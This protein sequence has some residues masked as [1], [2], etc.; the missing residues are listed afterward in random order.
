MTN[1]KEILDRLGVKPVND[2]MSTGRVSWAGKGPVIESFS[3]VDGRK[4]AEVASAER[5]DYYKNI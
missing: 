3:P 2:G 5:G 1:I 4:I